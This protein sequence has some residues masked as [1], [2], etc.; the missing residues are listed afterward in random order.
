MRRLLTSL[1]LALVL[2]GLTIPVAA[3]ANPGVM[4]SVMMDDDHLLYRGDQVRD[5]A[6]RKMKTLGVDYVRVS[7]LW[8]VVAENAKFDRR[9]KKRRNFRADN[10]RTYPK[11]NW[12]RYDRLVQAGKTLVVGIYFNVTGPGPKWAHAKAPKKQRRYKRTWKPKAREYFKFVKALGKRYDGTYKD[13]NDGGRV[14]PRVSFWSIYNEPN[15]QGWLTPQWQKRGS[16]V[17][18]WSPVMYRELWYYGRAALDATNHRDDVVLIG[19]TA[20]LG[21]RQHNVPSPIYP[22]RFIRELFCIDANGH[23]YTGI[24][25]KRRKCS[26]L[27]KIKGFRYTA[28]GHHPYTKLL[29]PTKRDKNRDSITIANI[30]ELSALLDQVSAKSG[31]GPKQ[32]LVAMTEFGYET[33]PPDPFS[34]ISPALQ[35]EYINVGDYLAYKDQ[36]VIANTQFL[37]RDVEPIKR[38]KKTDKRRYFTYQSGLYYAN[39]KPKPSATAYLLPLVVTGTGPVEGYQTGVKLWGWLRFLPPLTDPSNPQKVYI[40]FRPKGSSQF[41][42]LGN[43]VDVTNGLGFFET[44]QGVSGPGTLR[45]AWIEQYSKT[46]FYSRHVEFTG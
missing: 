30:G 6:L 13:E 41:F 26:M 15:Q 44:T 43:G 3:S 35:A 12:D 46:T 23:R 36:R 18:P 22:K 14:L 16:E 5:E 37:L 33:D 42:T 39:G 34:G 19:E 24:R 45:A 32:S 17:V 20:P 27:K 25:A 2:A 10:P 7:V 31:Y 1:A 38:Y 11:G 21:S 40:Q 9:G 29:A 8:N 4:F 28:W